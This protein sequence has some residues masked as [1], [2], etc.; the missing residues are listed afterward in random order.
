[1]SLPKSSM[2]D[3]EQT[4][5]YEP[6]ELSDYEKAWIEEQIAGWTQAEWGQWFAHL[7]A[8]DKIWWERAAASYPDLFEKPTAPDPVR[9]KAV[10]AGRGS[11][12]QRSARVFVWVSL[13]VI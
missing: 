13:E 12:D 5:Y 11:R 8:E 4:W 3:P 9:D 7:S 10:A 1:M 6:L 2:S